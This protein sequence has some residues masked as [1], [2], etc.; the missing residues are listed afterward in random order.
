MLARLAGEPEL[1]NQLVD[2]SGLRVVDT[3]DPTPEFVELRNGDNSR[4]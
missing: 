3:K 2:A 4:N 1:L